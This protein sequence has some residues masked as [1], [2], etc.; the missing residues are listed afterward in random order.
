[1]N[2]MG[3]PAVQPMACC[4]KLRN[5]VHPSMHMHDQQ[6]AS[7]IPPSRAFIY[8]CNNKIVYAWCP[9]TSPPPTHT[10]RQEPMAGLCHHSM[11]TART[12]PLTSLPSLSAR[13]SCL[14]PQGQRSVT[15]TSRPLPPAPP[16]VV[17]ACCGGWGAERAAGADSV[18]LPPL[19]R[20]G[21]STSLQAASTGMSAHLVHGHGSTATHMH[22]HPSR[23]CGPGSCMVLHTAICGTTARGRLP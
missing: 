23:E 13:C 18:L 5:P 1:M 17:S 21:K 6:S 15:L 14:R 2:P 12:T 19:C 11:H 9:A 20:L 8:P 22:V 10:H 3:M 4:G 7:P 16:D